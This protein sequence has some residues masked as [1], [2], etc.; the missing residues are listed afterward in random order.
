M[1]LITITKDPIDP[2]NSTK[3]LRY[4]RSNTIKQC[5]D[6][7]L[8]DWE[9]E[10]WFC[11][12]IRDGNKYYPLRDEWEKE[13]IQ[14]NDQIHFLPYVGEPVSI[15]LAIII[16]VLV[17]AVLFLVQSNIADPPESGDP[18]FSIDGKS[19]KNR[20]GQPIEDC[21]GRNKIWCSY[22]GSP[23]VE[24]YGD[25]QQ[26]LFQ[27]FVLGHGRHHIEDFLLE[28]TSIT[29]APSPSSTGT[30]VDF[31]ND[32]FNVKV[33]NQTLG[34]S[35]FNNVCTCYQVS[36]IEMIGTNQSGYTTWVGPF[37]INPPDTEIQLIALDI[38][39]P[40]GC[41]SVDPESGETES[42]GVHLRFDIREI[43]NEGEAIGSWSTLYN[44]NKR[45]AT[46][47]PIRKTIKVNAPS[48]A[49][50]Q[51]RCSRR[52]EAF[53]STNGT[54]IVYWDG[55]KGY[56]GNITPRKWTYQDWEGMIDFSVR[57]RAAQNTQANK[58]QVLA[59]R[60]LFQWDDT[61]NTWTSGVTRNPIWA[62]VE[63]LRRPWGGNLS[64]E[65]LDLD[66]LKLCADQA[67]EAGETF[68]WVFNQSMTVWEACKVC[69]SV[70]RSTPIMK[71]AKVS[72]VR[73]VPQY[74]PVALFNSE[75]IHQN[76]F[77][78][79]RRVWNNDAHDG[80]KAEYLDQSTWRNETVLA[81]LGTQQGYNPKTTKLRGVTNRD[82]A[83]KLANYLWASEHY[84]REIVKFKTTQSAIA[85][86]YGD[87][88]K[89][90]TDIASWGQ[91]GQVEE[92]INGNTFV[93]SEPIEWTNGS[94]HNL[95][96]RDKLGGI[97]GPFEVEPYVS[98]PEEEADN[99]KCQLV[100]AGVVDETLIPISD[101]HIKPIYIF[102]V[103][104]E[105]GILCKINKITYEG[106]DEI[107]IEAVVENYG[108]FQF[109]NVTA[110]PIT[111][112]T[113]LPIPTPPFV[114]NVILTGY[115]DATRTVAFSWDASTNPTANS[116]EYGYSYDGVTWTNTGTTTGVNGS[117]SL[118]AIPDP[119]LTSIL[120]GVRGNN[121]EG[122]GEY[123][124]PETSRVDAPIS[125]VDDNLTDPAS[126]QLPTTDG[127]TILLK[128]S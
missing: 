8:G 49:R 20:L 98:N 119:S 109:D 6:E 42:V 83:L 99:Y 105:D 59:E 60:E 24:Y 106:V 4:E 91:S 80:L 52:D 29:N 38:T 34:L 54:D 28:D 62:M 37:A 88:I 72:A 118:P 65:E 55:V 51:I 85:L 9:I 40:N 63:I 57:T 82:Q 81:T 70:C 1:A 84:N 68:D 53:T 33:G 32:E 23:Y 128:S 86:T 17:I 124:L 114:N 127:S 100:A 77:K 90:Q 110:P 78:I 121:A 7:L 79:Q 103:A 30:W 93:L 122:Y 12:L 69:C 25:N 89:V 101:D 75:S 13:K 3:C 31:P 39:M 112:P 102:G 74:V 92:I 22:A 116:Y 50:W 76:S 47:Q 43:N 126:L 11:V 58:F 97:Y 35:G 115:T 15:I 5:A 46:A 87:L 27:W 14:D 21:F 44:W 2:H 16:I 73:D 64:D 67:D 18:V 71:G 61:F 111:Y 120:I 123:G 41:Y 26:R 48:P 104:N 10:P 36:Q 113:L 66:G 56:R 94:T 45:F 107:S 108:R 117:I 96:F 19:N 125:L 95:T